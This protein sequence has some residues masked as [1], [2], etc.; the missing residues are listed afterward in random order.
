MKRAHLVGIGGVGMSALAQA[1][2]VRG[3][4]VTGSDRDLDQR[5]GTALLDRLR[6]AGLTL[7]PQDGSGVRDGADYVVVSTAI[8]SDNPDIQA[9][10]T[11]GVT[12]IH[13]AAM[14]AELMDDETAVAVTGTSGKST[15][16]GMIGAI[17]E[18][19]GVDPMVVNGAAVLN[20]ATETR[21]GNVRVGRGPWIFEADES[22]RSL[23]SY[24]PDWAVVTNISRDHF[25]EEEA[26]ALFDRFRQRVRRATIGPLDLSE[27][28]DLRLAAH[29]CQ[30]RWRDQEVALAVPGVHNVE[31]AVHALSLCVA[32]GWPLPEAARALASFRGIERRLQWVGTF[33]GMAIVDDYA[34]NPAKIAAAWETV[35]PYYRRVLAVWRPH[36]FGP[37][38]AMKDALSD[39]F[40]ALCRPEDRLFL[41]P[42]YYA[43]GTV[44]RTVTSEELA[45]RISARGVAVFVVPDYA[46]LERELQALA[47]PEAVALIMGARDPDL[48]LFCRRLAA[49]RAQR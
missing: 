17:L 37:L 4:L 30:F 31:N 40:P 2:S 23:M 19:L 38:A 9:A 29:G 12:L 32:M 41:L 22:D 44:A 20:W 46:T 11:K 39:L 10:R 5:G 1:M 43:G 16:T 33:R 13:R 45:E 21:I 8:E 49:A 15:V 3:W 28:R 26:R 27:V 7:Y 48:P 36:G 47:E 6:A 35:R 42:P 14:L 34:H 18:Q 25:H 24:R